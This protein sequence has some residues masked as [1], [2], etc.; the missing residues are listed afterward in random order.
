VLLQRHLR[1]ERVDSGAEGV[2]SGAE[3][4]DSGAEEYRICVM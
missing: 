4:V 3:G 2:D 1:R